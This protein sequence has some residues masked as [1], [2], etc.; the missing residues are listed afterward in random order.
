MSRNELSN[1]LILAVNKY[2]ISNHCSFERG[3]REAVRILNRHLDN[4]E[5]VKTRRKLLT[6]S[7]WK[8]RP[9]GVF[10]RIGKWM[11]EC[12]I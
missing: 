3:C 2:R 7:E 10:A 11:Y 12:G 5:R 1:D 8:R 9:A 6:K 4:G